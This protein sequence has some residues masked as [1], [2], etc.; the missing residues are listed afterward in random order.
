MATANVIEFG[1]RGPKRLSIL[2]LKKRA[3]LG[4][5]VMATG[6]GHLSLE[7]LAGVLLSATETDCSEKLGSWELRGAA[8]FAA[9]GQA[10]YSA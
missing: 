8:F 6:A 4:E 10:E 7:A 2:E 9:Q 1:H 3:L 5:L